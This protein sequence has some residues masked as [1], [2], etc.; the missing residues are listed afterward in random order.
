ME[1]VENFQRQFARDLRQAQN[2]RIFQ[3]LYAF[4]HDFRD[5]DIDDQ[6]RRAQFND[7]DH[8][9]G[10]HIRQ[11]RDQDF[12]TFQRYRRAQFND[13][14][15]QFQQLHLDSI[16][17]A[18]LADSH[19][20]G[21]EFQ[22][23][24]PNSLDIRHIVIPSIP[25]RHP[26]T[27]TVLR[28]GRIRLTFD[29]RWLLA[30]E[31]CRLEAVMKFTGMH[32]PAQDEGEHIPAINPQ[33]LM[34]KLGRFNTALRE[35]GDFCILDNIDNKDPPIVYRLDDNKKEAEKDKGDKDVSPSPGP[36]DPETPSQSQ[37]TTAP[38]KRIILCQGLSMVSKKNFPPP[39]GEHFASLP[40]LV[41][42]NH[43][44]D[45]INMAIKSHLSCSR[46]FGSEL[47]NPYTNIYNG[48]HITFYE[49][50]KPKDVHGCMKPKY[51]RDL[52]DNE[53]W[54]T[55][56]LYKK[57]DESRSNEHLFRQ[58]AFTMLATAEDLKRVQESK[59]RTMRDDMTSY[60]TILLLSPS[61]FFAELTNSREREKGSGIDWEPVINM[62][63]KLTAELA[64]I[65]YA[66][67][68]V[69]AQWKALNAYIEELVSNNFMD[70][71]AYDK[72]LSDDANLSRSRRYFW[73]IACL[74]EFKGSI[75]DNI[76]QWRMFQN[77]RLDPLHKEK[78]GERSQS[79]DQSPQADAYVQLQELE[80]QANDL[81]RDLQFILSQ[82]ETKLV[83][84]EALRSGV[85]NV[86]VISFLYP[87]IFHKLSLRVNE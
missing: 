69:A 65:V 74:T 36:A 44:R 31:R 4:L 45:P 39:E 26:D 80:N 78:R 87:I 29:L 64:C 83:A 47:A 22:Q 86:L 50:V 28:D 21:S 32:M 33:T 53:K 61:G 51:Y 8:P 72:L 35:F 25:K 76:K 63:T 2:G 85:S 23:H 18:D 79:T 66:L 68:E 40:F 58:S 57:P 9:Q 27:R 41:Y 3:I 71:K 48:F 55:G 30:Y 11:L 5:D 17:E 46:W 19:A 37:S 43:D 67:K 10:R 54:K 14:F 1:V 12:H 7:P 34:E 84:V 52:T 60:W 75:G 38:L 59:E 62:P 13:A 49:I 73:T 15:D 42:E 81:E 82:F 16:A 6:A 70:P 56:Y 77:A 20:E 24:R